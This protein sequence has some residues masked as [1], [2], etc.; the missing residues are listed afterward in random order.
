MY[1]EIY[2]IYAYFLGSPSRNRDAKA[3][4][5]KRRFI[6]P[7][8]H[9]HRVFNKLLGKGQVEYAPHER[10]AAPPNQGANDEAL[11]HIAEQGY[12]WQKAFGQKKSMEVYCYRLALEWSRLWTRDGFD[13]FTQEWRPIQKS[14]L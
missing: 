11:R 4:S 13:G 9:A 7:T 14:W 3:E 5:H 2:N 12:E 8:E 6:R 10:L 1:D